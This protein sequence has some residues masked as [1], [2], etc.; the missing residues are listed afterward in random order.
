MSRI[1]VSS[2]FQ[3]LEAHRTAVARAI[4]R[5]GHEDVAMEYYVAEPR[6]PLDRCLQDVSSSD[7]YVGIFARRYGF[8]PPGN[9]RSITEMEF[10]EAQRCDVDCL[11]FLL[12]ADAD[13]PA[14]HVEDGAGAERLAAL[15]A[16][17]VDRYLAGFF[18]TPDEL[19][20]ISTAALARALGPVRTPFDAMR[21]HRLWKAWR[22]GQSPVER[23]R[24]RQA[25]ANMGSPRYVAEIKRRLLEADTARHVDALASYLEELLN[26]VASRRELLPIFLDLLEHPDE[27]RRYFAVFQIGELA[28]RGVEL[29]P[30]IVT[31]LSK[32]GDDQSPNVRSQLAHAL[33][34]LGTRNSELP[35]V[36]TVLAQLSADTNEEVRHHAE[37]SST[38]LGFS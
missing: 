15:K 7:V 6:R 22:S 4:R 19:A 5:L 34:K 28:L 20:A 2:T 31:E 23:V 29:P 30:L 17:L 8:C 24:S 10:R 18:S 32:L 25:L 33:G 21:E 38:K 26:L 27:S 37:E 12:D 13:W 35:S 9:D 14:E 11:C 1:Y 3:D 16:T 36:R